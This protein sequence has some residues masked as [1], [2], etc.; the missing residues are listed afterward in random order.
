VNQ[1]LAILKDYA[2]WM[3]QNDHIRQPQRNEKNKPSST[4]LDKLDKRTQQNI[5]KVN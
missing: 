5:K 2:N 3:A 4:T 1:Y